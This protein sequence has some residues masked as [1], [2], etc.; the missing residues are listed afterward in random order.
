LLVIRVLP[1]L[2]NRDTAA[3]TTDEIGFGSAEFSPPAELVPLYPN[4][5]GGLIPVDEATGAVGSLLGT[6][7][8]AFVVVLELTTEVGLPS[9]DFAVPVAL[10]ADNCLLGLAIFDATPNVVFGGPATVAAIEGRGRCTPCRAGLCAGFNCAD[11]EEGGGRV[12]EIDERGGRAP[13]VAEVLVLLPVT[14]AARSGG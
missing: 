8:T 5:E 7:V 3:P 6:L 1:P 12:A 2:G 9:L 13:V 11:I 4:L 10:P 14:D